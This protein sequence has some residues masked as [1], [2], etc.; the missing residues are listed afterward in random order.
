MSLPKLSET[1][2]LVSDEE[3]SELQK[4]AVAFV[5]LLR[6]VYQN[7]PENPQAKFNYAWGLI[8]TDKDAF[9]GLALL[10]QIY[11]EVCRACCFS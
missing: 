7:N 10:R 1:N 5:L 6:Q 9:K 3:V 2:A 11:Q 8:R 4:V